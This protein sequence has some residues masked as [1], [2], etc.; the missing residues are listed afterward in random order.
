MR[1]AS[2]GNVLVRSTSTD[3]VKCRVSIPM[4]SETGLVGKKKQRRYSMGER[5]AGHVRGGGGR[6]M[7]RNLGARQGWTAI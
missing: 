6:E 4:I 5:Y 7:K 2:C 1:N 3:V